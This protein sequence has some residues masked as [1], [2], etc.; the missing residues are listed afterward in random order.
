MVCVCVVVRARAWFRRQVVDI[1]SEGKKD[2]TLQTLQAGGP[3]PITD[4]IL[5]VIIIAVAAAK[6]L[7]L[8]L[9]LQL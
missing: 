2:V 3:S 6:N 7:R 5:I 8:Q 9:P 1:Q 4:I